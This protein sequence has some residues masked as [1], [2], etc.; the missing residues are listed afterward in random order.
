MTQATP[1]L[2]DLH[3][4]ACL[5]VTD[6]LDDAGVCVD[7]AECIR[8]AASRVLADLVDLSGIMRITGAGKSTASM[9]ITRAKRTGFPDP[10]LV[11]PS[12]RLWSAREVV[13]WFNARNNTQ[14]ASA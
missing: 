13:A 11:M 8:L 14:E 2:D 5:L 12:T 3:C 9:W 7:R 1:D 4:S 10:V 6:E